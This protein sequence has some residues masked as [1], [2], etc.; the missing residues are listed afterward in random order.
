ML[1]AVQ[2]YMTSGSQ[3][4]S[5]SKSKIALCTIVDVDA[6]GNVIMATV[7]L[8]GVHDFD[9]ARCFVSK[10]GKHVEEVRKAHTRVVRLRKHDTDSRGK[11]IFLIPTETQRQCLHHFYI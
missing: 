3:R 6:K 8:E 4:D 2:G 7:N 9:I 11:R 10:H 1:R 5:P